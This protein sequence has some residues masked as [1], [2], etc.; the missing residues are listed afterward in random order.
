MFKLIGVENIDYV[1]KKT[2]KRVTGKKLY[3]TQNIPEKY[4]EGCKSDNVFIN[5]KVSCED[6][7]IG[8]EFDILCDRYGN[9]R[10]IVI[11]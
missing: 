1:S 2:G 5:E 8:C 11:E 7:Y 6:L 9:V 4:G 3:Y 10:Q